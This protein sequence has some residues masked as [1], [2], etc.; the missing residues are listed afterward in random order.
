MR[1]II[2]RVQPPALK[3][4][5]RP[6]RAKSQ[7]TDFMGDELVAGPNSRSLCQAIITETSD[8]FCAQHELHHTLL[9]REEWEWEYGQRDFGGSAGLGYRHLTN[10]SR[11]NVTS[12]C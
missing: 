9:G 2:A 11:S 10:R 7:S 12:M 8:S 5:S 3:V 6:I 1:P 4:L